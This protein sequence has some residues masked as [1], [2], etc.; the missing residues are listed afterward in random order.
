MED[1]TLGKQYEILINESP[2]K[3]LEKLQKKTK[4][5]LRLYRITYLN[6]KPILISPGQ[7]L[8]SIILLILIPLGIVLE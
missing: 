3:T 5:Q 7:E 1:V 2:R 6:W 8:I 4:K